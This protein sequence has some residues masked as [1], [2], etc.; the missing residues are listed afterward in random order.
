MDELLRTCNRV[1]L[2]LKENARSLRDEPPTRM[3]VRA[4]ASLLSLLADQ[5]QQ[6]VDANL[7]TPEGDTRETES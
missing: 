2:A 6:Q 1:A 5:L 3:H 4:I 7:P